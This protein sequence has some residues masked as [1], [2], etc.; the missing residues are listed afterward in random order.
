M[1]GTVGRRQATTSRDTGKY[2]PP[3]EKYIY[4]STDLRQNFEIIGTTTQKTANSN[5]VK[6]PGS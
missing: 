1:P 6:I 2:V 4:L 3:Q 5:R